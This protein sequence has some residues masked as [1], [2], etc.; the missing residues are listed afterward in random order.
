MPDPVTAAPPVTVEN[1][2]RNTGENTGTM[3]NAALRGAAIGFC[4]KLPAR[5]DFVA[6]G[7]PRSF[8]EAWHD[9]LQSVLAASRHALG[10]N[11][12]AA[13]LEAPIWRFALSPGI[14][15]PDAVLGLWMPSVDR[16]GRYFPL[17]FAAVMPGADPATLISEGGGFLAAVECA[18]LDALADDLAPDAVAARLAATASAEPN[19]AGTDPELCPP[20]GAL[21]WSA[22]SPR[23]SRTA[24][25]TSSLPDEAVFTGMLD[26]GSLS[27][28]EGQEDLARYS[29][30]P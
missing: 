1:T 6:A 7:L 21:W 10:E 5:G 11:W 25:A 19:D 16:V 9:W 18:G 3:E 2:G 4:G 23:V 24:F 20:A 15:G 14:C 13:W 29:R 30:E 8:V 12:V 27:P 22:G 28:A 17:T 26:A